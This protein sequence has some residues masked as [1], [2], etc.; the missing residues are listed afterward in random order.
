MRSME[1]P[2]MPMPLPKSGANTPGM[3]EQAGRWPC[4]ARWIDAWPGLHYARRDEAGRLPSVDRRARVLDQAAQAY[5]LRADQRTEL[6]RRATDHGR[7]QRL[8]LLAE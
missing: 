4:M 5:R 7:A 1:Q 2:G 8:P 3:G 6:L